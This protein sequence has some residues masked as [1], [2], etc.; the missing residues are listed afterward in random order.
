MIL[1]PK[2]ASSLAWATLLFVSSI[3]PVKGSASGKNQTAFIH[4]LNNVKFWILWF[5]D[6]TPTPCTSPYRLDWTTW[7][8]KYRSDGQLRWEWCSQVINHL[9][10]DTLWSRSRQEATSQDVFSAFLWLFSTV[11]AYIDPRI[12]SPPFQRLLS[13]A[14]STR[15]LE[16][17]QSMK[18]HTL[19]E[20][21]LFRRAKADRHQKLDPLLKVR[22]IPSFFL[23]TPYIIKATSFSGRTT[24]QT[25]QYT[26]RTSPTPTGFGRAGLSST[27][28]T[29]RSLKVIWHYWQL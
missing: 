21:K 11:H 5:W 7:S 19:L 9:G 10:G 1:L 27:S 8:W 6:V 14:F 16:L 22:Y 25:R 3:W 28:S 24:K 20:R 29:R 13:L 23:T 15:I 2:Y 18:K 26:T 17:K 12:F 4:K